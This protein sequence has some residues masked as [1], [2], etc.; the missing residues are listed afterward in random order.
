MEVKVGK[1]LAMK[2]KMVKGHYPKKIDCG[3]MLVNVKKKVNEKKANH[4]THPM[5]RTAN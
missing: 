4:P 3:R 5:H 2:R 1:K